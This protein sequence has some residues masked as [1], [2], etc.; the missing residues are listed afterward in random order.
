MANVWPFIQFVLYV[1]HHNYQHHHNHIPDSQ[2]KEENMPEEF[3]LFFQVDVI[4]K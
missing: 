2:I 3:H 4:Y 1:L